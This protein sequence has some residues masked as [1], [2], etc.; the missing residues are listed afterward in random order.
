VKIG[1]N[2]AESSKEVY[3][4]KMAGSPMMM[5]MAMMI[6]LLFLFLFPSSL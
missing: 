5:M 4:T 1:Q 3:G 6:Y 2:L